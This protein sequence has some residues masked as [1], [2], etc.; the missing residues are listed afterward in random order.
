VKEVVM[1]G[2]GVF[3]LLLFIVATLFG[4]LRLS[5][6]MGQRVEQL[7]EAANL[8]AELK[9]HKAAFLVREPIWVNVKVT[10]VGNEDRSVY[11]N[12]RTGLVIQDVKGK[13]YPCTVRVSQ[14]PVTIKAGETLNDKFDL[15]V[16]YG[17]SDNKFR[18]FG[19]LPAET[20]VVFY[21]A[22]KGVRSE[23]DTVKVLVPTGDELEAMNLVMEADDLF[24]QRQWNKSISI[25]EKV[26]EDHPE[27]AYGPHCLLQISKIYGIA[28]EDDVM[29]IA[30]YR[31][32]I[33]AYPNSREAVDAALPSMI[34]FYDTEPDSSGLIG[35]LNELTK[36]HPDTEVAE[37]AQKE[38]AKLGE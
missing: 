13:K 36:K 34:H 10:N 31:K 33:D 25:L 1:S 35:Y 15:L 18:L 8:K 9:T 19:Y 22:Q 12:S 38:L 26:V 24:L 5:S 28:L 23:I 29:L 17:I 20:Y 27:S 11:F 3:S 30:G 2:K 6:A 32:L 4:V 16:N 37:E 7:E 14:S 21:S